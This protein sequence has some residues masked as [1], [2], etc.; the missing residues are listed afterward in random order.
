MFIHVLSLAH[1]QIYWLGSIRESQRFQSLSAFTSVY[2]VGPS[3][4]RHLYDVGLRNIED[5]E[6]YYDVPPGTT[7]QELEAELVTPNGRK[8]T[9]KDKLPELSIK[10]ALALRLELNVPIPKEE[11]EEMHAIVMKE[12]ETI[13]PGCISTI[14]GGYVNLTRN[15]SFVCIERAICRYRRGKSQSNDVD[16]VISHPDIQR[17]GEETKDL[18]KKLTAHLYLKGMPL[19][20]N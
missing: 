15:M 8:V 20:H 3:T 6:R 13:Q 16:I 12:L 17:G 10:I 2:R 5:M 11:V 7:T 14:V 1:N 19:I 18:C 9:G 4:A